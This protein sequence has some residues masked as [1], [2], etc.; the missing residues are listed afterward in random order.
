MKYLG[1]EAKVVG[2]IVDSPSP[3]VGVRSPLP[4]RNHM[5]FCVA[6]DHKGK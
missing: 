2:N 4:N 6:D 1:P 3:G 5:T